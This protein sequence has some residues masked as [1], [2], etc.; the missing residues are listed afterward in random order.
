MHPATTRPA[1]A[2]HLP[3]TLA[4]GQCPAHFPPTAGGL[5][6][7]AGEGA[8]SVMACGLQ[9]S[10]WDLAQ[11]R[12]VKP[13]GTLQRVSSWLTGSAGTGDDGIQASAALRGEGLL[14]P[15]KARAREQRLLAQG[16]PVR[17][18]LQH[19][20]Q[21]RAGA[22]LPG[23]PAW[24][25][26]LAQR[27]LPVLLASQDE[28]AAL[29]QEA[30]GEV[31]QGPAFVLPG[32]AGVLVNPEG[33]FQQGSDQPSARSLRALQAMFIHPRCSELLRLVA[34]IARFPRDRMEA[35]VDAL[36]RQ[37]PGADAL[38]NLQGVVDAMVRGDEAQV[39]R[40]LFHPQVLSVLPLS[41]LLDNRLLDPAVVSRQPTPEEAARQLQAVV[42][43]ALS[44]AQPKGERTQ[45]LLGVLGPRARATLAN[46][47]VHADLPSLQ[48]VI[49]AYSFVTLNEVVRDWLAPV[50]GNL[51]A[52]RDLGVKVRWHER[53]EALRA[54]SPEE[55]IPVRL[56]PE[57]GEQ[58][59]AMFGKFDRKTRMAG[60]SVA[61][62]REMG[63]A[64]GEPPPAGRGTLPR[65]EV[66]AATGRPPLVV[67][68]VPGTSP[69]YP[70]Q[71][72]MLLAE[73]IAAYAD[74][75]AFGASQG[76]ASALGKDKGVAGPNRLIEDLG[77]Y[78]GQRL[79]GRPLFPDDAASVQATQRVIEARAH[80]DGSGFA[81]AERDVL[82]LVFGG[83]SFGSADDLRNLRRLVL[84]LH[85]QRKLDLLRGTA[86]RPGE[87][88]P[89]HVIGGTATTGTWMRPLD[90]TE[91]GYR[92]EPVTTLPAQRIPGTFTLP[93]GTLIVDPEH[94]V[95]VMLPPSP[96]AKG[97][98]QDAGK[99]AGKG[100]G[101]DPGPRPQAA[102]VPLKARAS[103]DPSASRANAS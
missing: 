82:G 20:A 78:I 85:E 51:D 102:G 5:P 34:G 55:P 30:T 6:P 101:H 19:Y 64:P 73:V 67:H 40:A 80:L 50:S 49:A 11:F 56:A 95:S 77:A 92:M 60:A 65:P 100:A 38:R 63:L 75:Y 18:V 36:V 13:V 44:H 97:A 42:A 3:A 74:G 23:E 70:L 15:A 25:G 71:P 37:R 43:D 88:T 2:F 81:Q 66:E 24:V 12:P 39:V 58:Q 68:I 94:V 57:P 72:A 4:Q 84:S 99:E 91:D 53:S 29:S 62:F 7:G 33:F 83:R 45:A 103:G 89:L 98:G 14:A 32:R 90:R 79:T 52:L 35:A 21:A 10:A 9:A 28:I 8:G 69:T 16:R 59:V 46:A 27:Q 22:R 96:A 76:F 31:A 61:V 41:P 87:G 47:F 1:Q 17:E 93:D 26:L 86:A 48:R 54:E